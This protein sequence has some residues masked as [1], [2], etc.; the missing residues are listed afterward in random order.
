MPIK[1]GGLS[2]WSHVE[3]RAVVERAKG[4]RDGGRAKAYSEISRGALRVRKLGSGTLVLREDAEDR[5][6]GLPEKRRGDN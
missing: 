2:R 1:I 6:A 5:I 3:V 4:E